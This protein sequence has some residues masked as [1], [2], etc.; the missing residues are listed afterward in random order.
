MTLTGSCYT[1]YSSI[2]HPNAINAFN[3]HTN[4]QTQANNPGHGGAKKSRRYKKSRQY[5]K[6][7]KYVGG[8]VVAVQ[9]SLYAPDLHANMKSTFLQTTAHQALDK[10]GAPPPCGGT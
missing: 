5:K 10:C 4:Q 6:S 3:N 7:R 9:G 1:S 8:N 2:H